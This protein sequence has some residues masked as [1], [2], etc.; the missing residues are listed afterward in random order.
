MGLFLAL[1]AVAQPVS[2]AKSGNAAVNPYPFNVNPSAPRGLENLRKELMVIESE[3]QPANKSSGVK[4]KSAQ[5]LKN[6]VSDVFNSNGF[7]QGKQQQKIDSIKSLGGVNGGGGDDVGIEFEATL[8]SALLKLGRS[9]PQLYGRMMAAKLTQI[10]ASLR[11]MSLDVSISARYQN[12]LQDS[13]AANDPIYRII[14]VNPAKW[15]AIRSGV[16]AEGI[17][18]HEVASILGLEKTGRYPITSEYVRAFGWSV[19]D[20]KNELFVRDRLAQA[21]ALNSD[22]GFFM[23]LAIAF[24]E[25]PTKDEASDGEIVFRPTAGLQLDF[26]CGGLSF[27]YF[28]RTGYFAINKLRDSDP[29]LRQYFSAFQVLEIRQGRRGDLKVK[30]KVDDAGQ[31]AIFAT[32]AELT[33]SYQGRTG[34]STTKMNDYFSYQ[35]NLEVIRHNDRATTDYTKQLS[36][37]VDL[38]KWSL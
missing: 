28:P 37:D 36:C 21:L 3:M 5:D 7:D 4:T 38:S 31:T 23:A 24:E 27:S 13:V 35:L 25:L 1:G 14:I 10:L 26:E 9:F 20:L 2:P 16:V 29:K 6:G 15:R 33:F 11:I 12:L 30:A 18:L 19:H 34:A 17:A 22:H 8:R 32:E